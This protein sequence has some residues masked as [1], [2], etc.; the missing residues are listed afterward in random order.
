MLA[1]NQ[2]TERKKVTDGHGRSSVARGAPVKDSHAPELTVHLDTREIYGAD[3]EEQTA[4]MSGHRVQFAD[5][6][7]SEHKGSPKFTSKKKIYIFFE[8]VRFIPF[9]VLNETF[10]IPN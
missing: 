7:P 9:P 5:L 3:S 8:K 1:L 6:P 4:N 10:E 2:R